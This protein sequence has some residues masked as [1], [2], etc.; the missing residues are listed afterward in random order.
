M[1]ITNKTCMIIVTAEAT[2]QSRLLKSSFQS[3][4]PTIKVSGPYSNSGMTNS[5]IDGMNTSIA[6][7]LL[8]VLQ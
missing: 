6:F 1:G 3:I 5:P 7:I 2:S 8:L 4:F